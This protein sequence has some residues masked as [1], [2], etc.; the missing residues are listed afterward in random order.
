MSQRRFRRWWTGVRIGSTPVGKRFGA[1]RDFMRFV[2]VLGA[3]GHDIAEVLEVVTLISTIRMQQ[4]VVSSSTELIL[5]TIYIQ[6]GIARALSR[7]NEAARTLLSLD[8]PFVLPVFF[9][10]PILFLL[11][12]AHLSSPAPFPIIPPPS[13]HSHCSSCPHSPF[14][15]SPLLPAEFN[16]NLN[17]PTPPRSLKKNPTMEKVSGECTSQRLTQVL[18]VLRPVLSSASIARPAAFAPLVG[19][20]SAALCGRAVLSTD[21][22][23]DGELWEA[24]L[25]AC[26]AVVDSGMGD[27][28]RRPRI[29]LDVRMPSVGWGGRGGGRRV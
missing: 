25:E 15:T 10:H 27:K 12:L 23:A 11:F 19:P 22:S 28:L 4:R 8:F 5:K 16:P 14:S 20:V 2:C 26:R 9:P 18:A 1:P 17:L 3:D 24:C 21:P 29:R 7:I 13:V 6:S